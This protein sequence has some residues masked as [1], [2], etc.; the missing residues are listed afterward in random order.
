MKGWKL[1]NLKKLELLE[2]TEPTSISS[3]AKVK[4]TKSLIT[5]SDVQRYLGETNSKNVILG[6]YGIGIVTETDANLLE[7]EKGK[8]VYIEPSSACGECYNCKNDNKKSC[9]TM[10]IA[11]EDKN[12]FLCDFITVETDKLYTL[13]ESVSDS[14]ALFI[15]YLSNA[16]A[17]VDKLGVQKGDYVSIIGAN[18][19]GIILAQLLIYY[20]AVPIICTNSEEG[21]NDAKNS[22]IY[23]VL[24]F[25]DNWA[26]EVSTIT[27]GRLTNSAVYISDCNI[28]IAK[29]FSLVNF[30]GNV[31]FT[32][33]TSKS[34]NVSFTQ[35][36]KKGLVIH[37]VN[38]GFGYAESSINL[39]ANKAID[40]SA[41]NIKKTK[42]ENVPETFNQMSEILEKNGTFYES[43]VEMNIN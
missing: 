40:L 39:I 5:L 32:G 18:T 8:H 3:S 24:G 34:V 28:P 31:V 4:I 42:Y 19:F 10:Q 35:A 15:G 38:S 33:I 11:G 23:Y 13:P 27:G 17:I 29:A 37:C 30:G 12:G 1:N 16:I 14:D 25:E 41:L 7:L 21:F 26:K 22:G 9:S 36:I 6:S 2:V 43:I 20:Q